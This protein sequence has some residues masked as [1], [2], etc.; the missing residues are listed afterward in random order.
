MCHWKMDFEKKVPCEHLILAY[1]IQKVSKILKYNNNFI[2]F[3]FQNVC[4]K[5]STLK[6]LSETFYQFQIN[7]M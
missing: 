4:N 6:S 5:I 3:N 1:N 2:L 7:L